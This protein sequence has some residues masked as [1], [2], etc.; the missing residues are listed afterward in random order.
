MCVCVCVRFLLCV[1]FLM[2]RLYKAVQN[3]RFFVIYN[4]LAT[5]FLTYVG[6]VFRLTNF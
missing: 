2:K 6:K 3:R 5:H 4:F 1:A